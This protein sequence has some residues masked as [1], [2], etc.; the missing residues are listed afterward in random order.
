MQSA[1]SPASETEI[2]V[3]AT[4]VEHH[5]LRHDLAVIRLECT[6]DIVPFR[7]GQYV[8]VTVPQRPNLPR[9]LSP[10][11]PPSMDGKLEF[12]VRTV[13]GGWVSGAI[14][15]DTQPGDVW[16]ITSPRGGDL[17]LDDTGRIAIMVAAGTGLAPMRALILDAAR[18]E[19][20]PRTFLFIGAR[21]PRDLYAADLLALLD[22][23]LPW[24][25]V[26]PVVE[27][28]EDPSVPDPWH[29]RILS[30]IGDI[31]ADPDE[32]LEGSLDEIV[33]S[34]GAFGDHQV[35]VCGPGAMV[36]TT[37]QRLT[38]SGTPME[39]IRFDPY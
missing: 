18:R 13:P 23:A 26:V 37:V 32:L 22:E 15:S 20:P 16:T 29:Q 14:V 36:Q 27:S 31:G 9:R 33:T 4:V 3:S 2:A 1:T 39:N 10:A 12:H 24:L 30:R 17:H 5:R 8:D 6:E 38:E 25:T 34:Y 28:V 7:A 35:L 19:N 21:T 11:L